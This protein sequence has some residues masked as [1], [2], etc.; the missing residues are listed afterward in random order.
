MKKYK[1]RFKLA[2]LA[3]RI[4]GPV[5][6][7]DKRGNEIYYVH[8]KEDIEI[9][10][11][12]DDHDNE[13]YYKDVRDNY[14]RWSKYDEND[15]EIWQR[16]SN[17]EGFDCTYNEFNKEVK[18]V[19]TDGII[20]ISK[21][22]TRGNCIDFKYTDTKKGSTYH[23]YAV[24]SDDNK[25]I[26]FYDSLGNELTRRFDDRGNC[27]YYNDKSFITEREFNEKGECI[28]YKKTELS[29]EV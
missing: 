19:T 25:E 18:Y 12:Y 15:N 10:R 11:G 7:Y 5:T 28:S 3:S 24:Y 16:N 13:I 14:E 2:K 22:D 9:I 21:Y 26:Y 6:L 8:D 23:S 1:L 4:I 29:K 27:I 20:R 17:G